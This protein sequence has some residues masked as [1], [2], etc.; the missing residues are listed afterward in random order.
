M[1]QDFENLH[2]AIASSYEILRKWMVWASPTM[3]SLDECKNWCV[4]A[5]DRFLQNKEF[6]IL[7][8][9]RS[10]GEIL[11]C[12]GLHRVDWELK[13]FEIGYWGV[14]KHSGQGYITE[15][16][17]LLVKYTLK[18]YEAKRVF[19]TVDELNIK[20]CTLAERVGFKLEGLLHNDR[21]GT[22]GKLRN[23]KVYAIWT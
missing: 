21:L 23:T 9:H 7:I 3:Q 1:P 11:G 15:A 5:Y 2:A 22:D 14:V 19:L 6:N 20:S 16:I 10:N 12:T 8:C 17:D 18:E 4:G 13:I